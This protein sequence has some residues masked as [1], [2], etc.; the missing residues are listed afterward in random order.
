[1]SVETMP[2]GNETILLVEDEAQIRRVAVEVL[3]LL[4]YKV[5]EAGN[6]IQALQLAEL[7]KEPIHLLLTDVVMPKMNGQDVADKLK[8]SH[9]ESSVLFM[10]GYTGDIIATE[11]MLEKDINFLGKPFAPRTLALKVREVLDS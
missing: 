5:L 3:T 10:S 11:G 2:Q 9:P 6:G 8:N 7:I 4:G 1:M